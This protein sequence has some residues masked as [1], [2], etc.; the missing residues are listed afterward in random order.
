M[1]GTTIGDASI[2]VFLDIV[3]DMIEIAPEVNYVAI[4]RAIFDILDEAK[5]CNRK[6]TAAVVPIL[7]N[8]L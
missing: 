3:E 2:C 1:K 6:C 4:E 7:H 5:K 8:V